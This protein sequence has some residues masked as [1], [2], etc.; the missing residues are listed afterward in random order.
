MKNKHCIALVLAFLSMSA[1]AQ[2]GFTWYDPLDT[3]FQ[4]IEGQAFP[5]ECKDTYMR[6]SQERMSTLPWGVAVNS[7]HS[8]GLTLRFHTDASEIRVNYTTANSNYAMYHMPSTGVSGIDLYATDSHGKSMVCHGQASFTDNVLY[9]FMDLTYHEDG[10]YDYELFFPLYNG[11]KSMSIGVPEGTAFHFLEASKEKPVLVY[12][13]SIAHGACASRPAMAW[14]NQLK[15]ELQIPFINWGFSGNGLLE[16]TMFDMMVEVDACLYII[17]CMPNMNEM[18]DQIVPRLVEGIHK[19]RAKT[20]IPILIVEHDGYTSEE[21]REKLKIQYQTTN[22]ECR[23]AFDQ[24]KGEGIRNLWYLS[25]KEI[26]MNAEATVDDTHASDI[27]MAIY[28]KAYSK[29]IRKI[30]HLKKR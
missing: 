27:G 4:V 1:E 13:T 29:K 21:T 26:A 25:H 2:D 7:V 3:S 19:L 30:L 16:P 24:L 28:A 12:G 6:F 14:V 23:K 8:A 10:G 9:K 18:P 5:E 11:V 20:N 15:R 22:V 17:D